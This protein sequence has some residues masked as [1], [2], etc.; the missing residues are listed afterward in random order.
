MRVSLFPNKLKMLRYTQ[1][2][3]MK[4]VSKILDYKDTSM[5]SRWEHGH[6][7]PNTRNTFILAHLYKVLPHELLDGLWSGCARKK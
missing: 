1:G 6:L 3:S 4:R 7:I 5:L 2:L